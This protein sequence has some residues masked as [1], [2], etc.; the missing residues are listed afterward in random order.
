MDVSTLTEIK[1]GRA[2]FAYFQTTGVI[3]DSASVQIIK[4]QAQ[5]L[6]RKLGH[7]QQNNNVLLTERKGRTGEYWPEVVTIRTERSEVRTKR[8]RANIPQAPDV[9]RLDN[10]IQRINHYSAD[11]LVCFVNTYPLDSDLSAG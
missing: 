8:P 10:A 9:Q 2:R 3:S 5:P 1:H 11:S 7:V 6:D 4:D